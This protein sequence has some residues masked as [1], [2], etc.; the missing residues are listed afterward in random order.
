MWS[1]EWIVLF[2][3]LKEISSISI[4]KVSLSP[5]SPQLDR[6]FDL[7]YLWKMVELDLGRVKP[8]VELA[9]K[10]DIGKVDITSNLTVDED[11]LAIGVIISKQE[12]I[13]AGNPVA[14][15]VFITL[16][17]TISYEPKLEDGSKLSYGTI[18][19]Q[20]KGKARSCLTAE[21]VALNFLQRLSGIA[22]L[23]RRFVEKIEGTGAKILDTRKTTP[24]LRYLEKYAVKVGGGENH[25]FS[26]DEL[27]LIK[28]NHIQAAGGILNA[29]RKVR[30]SGTELTIE[31][32]TKNLTEVREAFEAGVDRIMLDN[33]SAEIMAEAV[34]MVGG[35]VE[36]EASGGVNL[37]NVK[38]IADTGVNY[39]SIGAITHSVSAIDMSL[40]LRKIERI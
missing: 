32:E 26:L 9:L 12:G 7:R 28:D 40:E 31:V 21:R 24:G 22:T 35:K 1:R 4:S 8:T 25:R 5:F 33:M 38:T 23:T 13:L 6:Q 11:A 19:A 27:I 15:L 18:V 17:E 34:K 16:D 30:E 37:E 2:L 3:I 36:L 39:I 29:V 10:E 20:I 14:E